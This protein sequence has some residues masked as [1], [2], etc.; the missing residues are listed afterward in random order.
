MTTTENRH[1]VVIAVTETSPVAALWEAALRLLRKA[2]ADVVAL[3][4]EDDRWHRVASLPFTREISR[5]GGVAAD[6]TLERARAVSRERATRV[7]ELL[8]KLAAESDLK[9]AFEIL[10]ETDAARLRELIGSYENVLIAPS[11]ISTRPIFATFAE[12]KCRVELVEA[13]EEVEKPSYSLP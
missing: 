3:Y 8:L 2:P 1:R 4:F 12:L 9:P 10:P 7:Q 11:F 5:F 13:E 6:F